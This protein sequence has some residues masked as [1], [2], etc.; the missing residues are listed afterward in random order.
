M[1]PYHSNLFFI[2]EYILSALLMAFLTYKKTPLDVRKPI[3]RKALL[4]RLPLAAA[5]VILSILLMTGVYLLHLDLTKNLILIG[6]LQ[7][8]MT[9]SANIILGSSW[10]QRYRVYP[11]G[12]ELAAV[13]ILMY[14]IADLFMPSGIKYAI[15][16]MGTVLAFIFP[17]HWSDWE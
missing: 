16:V 12:R 9:L 6:I 7:L 1:N 3:S 4:K 14:I 2:A 13:V 11:R 5:A 10:I 15:L 17:N 8:F